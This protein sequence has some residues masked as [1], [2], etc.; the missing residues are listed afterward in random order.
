MERKAW[1]NIGVAC[2][3][4]NV[5]RSS[6][7]SW[8]KRQSMRPAIIDEERE[9]EQLIITEFA[10]S[11]NTYGAPRIIDALG[12]KSKS[13]GIN[14]VRRKMKDLG[15]K[16]VGAR[17][18][19]A[20]TNSKHKHPVFSNLL[21]RNFNLQQPNKAWVCDITYLWTDEG[22]YYLAVVIDLFSR[23]VI[24][25]K[26]SSRMTKELVIDALKNAYQTRKCPVGVIVHSDRGS[27]Y[28]SN[29]Y[30]RVLSNYGLIGSMSRKGDCW[31]NAV[32][33][34]FFATLKK[35]YVYQTKF[36]TRIQA[37][38]GVFDYIEAWYNNE[39][40]HSKL[41][42]LSPKEFELDYMDVVKVKFN[43][44]ERQVGRI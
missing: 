44:I 28:A 13:V 14:K 1:I 30:K 6:Y 35:E 17:K 41:G 34:S 23:K 9:L 31:D 5:K 42:G 15:L 39:R 25:F 32:P 16:P 12:K 27:Q 24:G 10:K 38:L 26:L 19:K 18:Y 37:H 4:L 8:V 36:R 33:E 11:R 20:T 7:Y 21:E 3:V 2:D 22:W 43:Q 29:E 40:I